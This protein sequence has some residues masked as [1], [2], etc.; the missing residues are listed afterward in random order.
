MS[1][2]TKADFLTAEETAPESL[3]DPTA[4][5]D[6]PPVSPPDFHIHDENSCN[7]WVRKVNDARAR[8]ARALAWAK[9]EAARADADLAFWAQWEGEAKAFASGEL[10]ADNWRRKSL[11]LPAGTLAFRAHPAKLVVKDEDA[12]REWAKSE[13]PAAVVTVT[14][15]KL[16]RAALSKEFFEGEK[17]G[18]LPDGCTWEPSG[19]GFSV[20][21]K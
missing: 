12:A 2:Q 1:D 16:D 5:L 21:E 13:V 4:E 7:W 6:G 11:A 15:E 17:K 9:K 19:D 18:F 14:V 8:K 3:A 20:R 10:A